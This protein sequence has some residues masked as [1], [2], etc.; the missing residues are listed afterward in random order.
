MN[1]KHAGYGVSQ[2]DINREIQKV[3]KLRSLSYLYE[4]GE[5]TA[6]QVLEVVS[7]RPTSALENPYI[8]ATLENKYFRQVA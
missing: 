8:R 6:N 5:L 7:P 4:K 1:A 2:E 3:V